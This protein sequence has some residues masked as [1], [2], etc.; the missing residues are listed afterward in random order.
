MSAPFDHIASA[1]DSYFTRSTIGQLQRRQVW[2]YLEEVIP[3][4]H[5]LDILELNC[6]TGEDAVLFGNRGFNIIATDISEEMLKMTSEKVTHYSLQ[7]KI[8]S[9]YL[10]LNSFD[11]RTFDKKFDLV[12]SN[13]GGINCIS[14]KA[15][16]Q[17]LNKLPSILAPGGRFIAV[18]MPK[19]CLWET[20]YFLLKLRPKRAFRRWTQNAVPVNLQ[21]TNL[22]IWYYQPAQVRTWSAQNFRFMDARPVGAAVPPSYLEDFFSKRKSWLLKLDAV[23]RSI[24]NISFLSGFADHFIIDLKVQ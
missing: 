2:S 17:L 24:G 16:Q 15:F 11:G 3:R 9:H 5:G 20:F 12:F 4:L 14:P 1:Y 18:I 21:G 7:N 13:F 8:S 6:G 22:N 10:D 23:E 19:F